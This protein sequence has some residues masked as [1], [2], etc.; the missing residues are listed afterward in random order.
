LEDLVDPLEQ[1]TRQHAARRVDEK[2]AALGPLQFSGL[3]A[4]MTQ[5]MVGVL[6]ALIGED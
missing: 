2:T 1:G 4:P 5:A 3:K 6:P